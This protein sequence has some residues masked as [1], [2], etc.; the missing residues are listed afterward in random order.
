M[1]KKSKN[2]IRQK[3]RKNKRLRN[4]IYNFNIY[5]NK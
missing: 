3:K 1:I 2:K 5:R 4:E